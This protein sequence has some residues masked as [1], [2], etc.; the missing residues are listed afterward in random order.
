MDNGYNDDN[1][2]H[3]GDTLLPFR[4]NF[5]NTTKS[6]EWTDLA[7]LKSPQRRKRRVHNDDILKRWE[8]EDFEYLFEDTAHGWQAEKHHHTADFRS[9]L[10]E[11]SPITKLDLYQTDILEL[12]P[13]EWLSLEDSEVFDF[14]LEG[15][16]CNCCSQGD[17]DWRD[18][19]MRQLRRRYHEGVHYSVYSTPATRTR[20]ACREK[21]VQPRHPNSPEGAE[22]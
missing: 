1:I 16:A 9:R 12:S 6:K 4:P 19:F 14:C 7:W 5:E 11:I 2:P 22:I 3:L 17:K 8:T 18:L 15:D 20:L 10:L 21:F 13:Q